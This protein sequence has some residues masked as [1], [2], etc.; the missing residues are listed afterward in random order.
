M[1]VHPAAQEN[2]LLMVAGDLLLVDSSPI[3]VQYAVCTS[4][5][6]LD[7]VSSQAVGAGMCG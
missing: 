7:L 3:R 6:T 5:Q 1:P 2:A 4:Q